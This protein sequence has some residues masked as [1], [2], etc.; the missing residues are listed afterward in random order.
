MNFNTISTVWALLK[1]SSMILILTETARIPI[2]ERIK[3]DNL[4]YIE[5][6]DIIDMN[7][8]NA[9]EEEMG[10]LSEDDLLI[11]LLTVDGF[12]NKGYCNT[13]SPFIKPSGCISKYIFIRLDIP[14][15]SLLSALNTRIEKVE[16]IIHKY[17]ALHAGKKVRATTDKGT[18][19]TVQID[20]QELLPYHARTPGG[21]AFLPPAEISEELVPYTAN[22]T[23]VVDITVGELRFGSELIDP[24]GI[25]DKNVKIVIQNGLVVGI[26]GGDIARR[27]KVGF[28]KLDSGLQMLVELGHGLSD[29]SPTGI[30]G[31]DE[32][33]NGTCHF[34]I[35]NRD[36]YHV[37]VVVSNP[38]IV[39]LDE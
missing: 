9:Y 34:G 5:K 1:K 21:N 8:N 26:S 17:Q 23:I 3:S 4:P 6:A 16:S 25:V 18:D 2:A 31:V 10:R 7:I 35:G 11:V 30:I 38:N 29:L 15:T 22:G 33:M 37:D 39:I 13:F 28:D 12:M 24:L 27:L 32:S 19:I 20:F 36:P 14:E